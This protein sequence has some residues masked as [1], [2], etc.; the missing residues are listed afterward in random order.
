MLLKFYCTADR[1]VQLQHENRLLSLQ[2][3]HK[4]KVILRFL[5]LELELCSLVLASI[6]WGYGFIQPSFFIWLAAERAEPLTILYRHAIT[7]CSLSL[8]SSTIIAQHHDS[9]IK[10][11]ATTTR[12]QQY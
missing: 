9:S 11:A 8:I 2:G 4:E 7:C 5:L 10:R 3:H 12:Q 6:L 1:V